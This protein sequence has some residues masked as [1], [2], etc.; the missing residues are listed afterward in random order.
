MISRFF[1]LLAVGGLFV[2][3]AASLSSEESADPVISYYWDKARQTAQHADSA[4][5]SH[6]FDFLATTFRH[7]VGSRG[8]ILRT[9]T[10][11]SR[12]FLKNGQEDSVQ[13]LSGDPT[14]FPILDINCPSLFEQSYHL[15]MFPNDLGGADLAIGII[16]D[17]GSDQPDG[18]VIIDRINHHL[19][20][21][22]LYYPDVPG[23]KRLTRS[24]RFRL[25]E[26]FAFPDSVWEVGTKLGV[27]SEE[28]YR[29][30]TGISD[31]NI[32]RQ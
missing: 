23:Y 21:L 1:M 11:V 29:L 22:Y 16:S 14:R 31:I 7:R 24:F 17:S 6:E 28:C 12:R 32:S 8:E 15:N 25:V 9:D 3:A 5:N 19:K 4:R 10:L 27:F 13:V 26:G 2:A 30:E 20:W 18:L